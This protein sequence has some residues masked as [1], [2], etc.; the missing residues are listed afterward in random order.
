[1]FYVKNGEIL[2]F[3]SIDHFFCYFAIKYVYLYYL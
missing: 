3:S 1:M 2:N